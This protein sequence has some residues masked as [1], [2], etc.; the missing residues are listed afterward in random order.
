MKILITTDWYTPAVNGVVTSVKNLQREL[1]R[2]GHEVRILT[3]SQ[4]LHSWSRDGVTAIGSVNAGRIYPGARLRTAMAGRWV[5]ELMDWRPDVIHSQCEFSTFF[6]ARRI[7][8]ELD[9]PLVHT[10]HTVY[11][12]YTH[13]FSP[14][15]RWGRCAVAAFS[16]WV[17]A[18]VDGMIAPTGKVR[19]LLQGYGVRCPVFVV[20]TGIDL[21]RFQQEGDPMRRAV[22]RA[23][24][25]IPA[26]NT[27]LV[28]VGRL[29]EEKNI[30]ELLKLR[31]SLGS[32]PV[33]LL[34]VGDGPDRP[35]LEQVAHD[36]RLEA[37]AVIFAG[38]VPPEEVPEWYRLGDLFVSASSS[39][40]QGLTYIEALAAGVPALCRAD[41]CLEGVILEGENG[42]QYHSTAE[43]RQR[44]E[45]FL[46]SPETHEAL[47]RRAAE[48]AE[49]FSAQRFAQRVERIYQM[50]LA[51]RMP[52]ARFLWFGWTDPHLI[53]QEIRQAM[54]QAPEN[55]TFAGFVDRE[56]LREA[57]CGADV[58]AFMSHEETEGIVVLEALACGIPTVV[59]DIPVYNGWLREGQNVYKASGT[60]EFQ[61]K[62]E[63]LLT[64]TLPDLTA[65]GRRV[66]EERSLSVMG[67]RLREVYRRMDIL[68]AAQPAAK[69]NLPQAER[70][71]QH[72]FTP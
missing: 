62:A 18:Q 34:L 8:E 28:C 72:S 66:A 60:D 45:E 43:F 50:Q 23:S 17:A 1:E 63:G 25:G 13:Y 39:E 68:P 57:Y 36:L 41:L 5:R 61:Q 31:A 46:A 64:G 53:P 37:P 38:M 2:R 44:L 26:E 67:E 9:V 11:E 33:T 4:S 56:T 15:V 52:E 55:V 42:W 54:E 58:F 7:A 19:G 16:R 32:R 47:K 12:D 24:L 51:R 59:R 6:L 29:A 70:P 69:T 14:S 27:V 49:Q 21:R 30:Q 22:L 35:R 65:A 48:S 10:Y 71:V 40:T 3:L 20:P